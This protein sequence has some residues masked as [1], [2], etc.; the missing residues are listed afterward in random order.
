M[1]E[2]AVSPA[3]ASAAPCALHHHHSPEPTYTE[4]HHVVPQA[5]QVAWQPPAPWSNAGPS[6]DRRTPGG[7]PVI[8][9][10]ARTTP[11]CRTGHGNVHYWLV[12]IMRAFAAEGKDRPGTGIGR[13]VHEARMNARAKGHAPAIADLETATQAMTRWLDA[14][15]Q[16]ELL[17]AAGL[18][19]EI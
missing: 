3:A 10:D 19:G 18:W 15:G 4:L 2:D 13:A 12:A 1:S 16:L 5:W 9:W 7:K 17:V 11:I 6:P 8:L 14:G